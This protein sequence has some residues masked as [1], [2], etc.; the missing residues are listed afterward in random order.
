[1]ILTDQQGLFTADPRKDPNGH[2]RRS[3]PM[4]A[5][6]ELEAMAGG[7]GSSLGRGGMLT[8][9]LA[10]KRAAHSGANT[11][12]ASGR[13]ADVLTRLASGE[14]I[15]T[16]LDRAHRAHGGAQAVDGRSPAGARP[17]S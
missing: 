1:M 13:E 16:Q 7:A 11:V 5:T 2:A 4:P 6:P 10:A 8:K 15:G 17:A 14:A 3:R 9:I 12:I